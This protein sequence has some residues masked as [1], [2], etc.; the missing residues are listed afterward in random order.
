MVQSGHINS[1]RGPLKV[2]VDLGTA[3]IVM[4]VVDEQNRPVAG[5]TKASKVVRDGIVVD[6]VGAVQAIREMKGRLEKT[7]R[8]INKSCYSHSTGHP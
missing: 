7:R 5:M 2:G 6:Y 4:A 3:N 1:F 8:Y